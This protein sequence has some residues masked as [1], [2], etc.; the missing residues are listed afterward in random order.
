MNDSRYNSEP[1][2]MTDEHFP[3][4]LKDL[5]LA[6]GLSQRQLAEPGVSYAYISRLEAG[7]RNASGKAIKTLARRLKVPEAYLAWGSLTSAVLTEDE[8]LT[9]ARF[10][11][12]TVEEFQ[13]LMLIKDV[14][15]DNPG[16]DLSHVEHALRSFREALELR[17]SAARGLRLAITELSLSA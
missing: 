3:M 9:L 7:T 8:A 5:R 2:K 10:G 14:F 4:R 15:R 6:R 12:A 11:D 13:R 17:E 1:I 16:L